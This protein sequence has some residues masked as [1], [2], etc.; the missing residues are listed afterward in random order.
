LLAE[1]NLA[2]LGNQSRGSGR[3]VFPGR[4]ENLGLLVVTRQSVN[5]ALNENKTE[6]GVLVFTVLFQML[7][8]GNGLLDEVIQIL[9]DG[10]CKTIGLQD[11]QDLVASNVSHL[12]NTVRISEND[13]N[14]RW[15]QTLL[16]QFAD[17]NF[18]YLGNQ[19]RGSGGLVFPG[20][21]ENLGLLVV[22]SQ[23]VN[24]ALNEN[25]T[26]LGVLVLAVL[27]QMLSDG[28]G[29]LNEVIQILRDGR[30]KT[31]GLQDSQDLVSSHVSHLGD[32]VRISEN[33]TNL[34]WSQTLLGQFADMV[35]NLRGCDLQP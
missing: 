14:L 12:G 22:T 34:R 15:C 9:R 2:Y 20:R 29:L 18:D 27:L 24:S 21:G 1:P 11:S 7:S 10:R 16:G 30:C 32:T 25:K 5:S 19:S 8:D 31:I 33:D 13:T 35:R 17:T 4:G 26:E 6:L 28:N 3:F 23:S